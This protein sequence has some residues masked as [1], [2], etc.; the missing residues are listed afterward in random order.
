M[1]LTEVLENQSV[2]LNR[3][4][5]K[6]E[7]VY[8]LIDV[9]EEKLRLDIRLTLLLLES[10][11]ETKIEEIPVLDIE[12]KTEVKETEVLNADE[13]KENPEPSVHSDESDDDADDPNFKPRNRATIPKT[14]KTKKVLKKKAIPKA[15]KT[16]RVIE[17]KVI[18]DSPGGNLCNECGKMYAD[19]KKLLRHKRTVH[20]KERGCLC[21]ECGKV[22]K[23]NRHLNRHR[24]VVH[25][26]EVLTYT[27]P[28]CK[29]EGTYKY[30][31]DFHKHKQACEAEL[32]EY[33]ERYVCTICDAKFGTYYNWK[34][35]HYVCSGEKPKRSQS[36]PTMYKCSY[37]NCDYVA[38]LKIRLKN[39]INTVHLNLPEIK[40]HCCE[41]CGKAFREPRGLKNHLNTVHGSMRDH[42]CTT[43][44][45]CF[46]TNE[47]LKKHMKIHS[48][49][50]S[51]LCP[52]P[53]CQKKFKQ[54]AVLYR[55][56]LS[57]QF[58]PNP[59]KNK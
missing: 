55:H 6:L 24:R 10:D 40:D 2:I 7:D 44:G 46:K 49:T 50:Y 29:K 17:K 31:S 23:T 1:N 27:C 53:P 25:L 35:H 51:Y 57:C 5:T 9:V 37:E 47:I 34:N 3:E 18:K 32:P 38:R 8:S 58:N 48:D 4:I 54:S 12:I 11:F 28:I 33:A 13:L 59:K 19:A 42:T 26:K 20:V 52:F 39:H 16:K 56:K 43:C 22:Y 30:Y 45:S 41:T 14:E 36:K 15:I 21:N